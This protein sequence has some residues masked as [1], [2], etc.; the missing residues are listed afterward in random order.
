M[1]VMI[2]PII[3]SSDDASAQPQINRNPAQMLFYLLLELMIK[4]QCGSYA[5]TDPILMRV[6][7]YIDLTEGWG[8]SSVT[9]SQRIPNNSI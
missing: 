2:S 1:T 6:S 3:R 9:R 8:G 7:V 4:Q 5:L